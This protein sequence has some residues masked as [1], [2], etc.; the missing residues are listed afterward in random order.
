MKL[1]IGQ[2]SRRGDTWLLAQGD[3]WLLAQ[4]L[5]NAR[6]YRRV[7]KNYTLWDKNDNLLSAKKSKKM[8]NIMV[9]I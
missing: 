6:Y 8:F 1:S 3:T 5:K 2:K 9:A 4:K 7:L